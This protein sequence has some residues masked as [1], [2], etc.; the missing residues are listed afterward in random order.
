MNTQPACGLCQAHRF[1]HL[2][3]VL[4]DL[5]RRHALM[6]GGFRVRFSLKHSSCKNQISYAFAELHP[7]AV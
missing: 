6:A 3:R 1:G 7:E 4:R 5:F 2:E